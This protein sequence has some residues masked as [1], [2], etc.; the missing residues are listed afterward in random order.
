LTIYKII[1]SRFPLVKAN[2][3]SKSYQSGAEHCSNID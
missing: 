1:Y 2:S 3:K